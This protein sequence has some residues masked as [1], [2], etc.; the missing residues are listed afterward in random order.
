M[1]KGA[2]LWSLLLCCYFPYAQSQNLIANGGFEAFTDCPNCTAGVQIAGGSISGVGL[3]APWSPLPSFKSPEYYNECAEGMNLPLPC[4]IVSVPINRA[5][6]PNISIWG[7]GENS[8]NAYIGLYGRHND[9][10]QGLGQYEYV[11]QELATPLQAGE[12]Y[13]AGF[14]ARL[15]P[16]AVSNTTHVGMLITDQIPTMLTNPNGDNIGYN[17]DP[18]VLNSQFLSLTEWETYTETFVASGGEKYVIL[19]VFKPFLQQTSS[20][21]SQGDINGAYLLM[22]NVR[23]ELCDDVN[24]SFTTEIE[25]GEQGIVIR[26]EAPN[27]PAT[28]QF[29]LYEM[30][31]AF[32]NNPCTSSACMVDPLNPIAIE[33]GFDETFVVPLEYDKYYII[34]HGVYNDCTPWTENRQLVKLPAASGTISASATVCEGDDILIFPQDIEP[35]GDEAWTVTVEEIELGQPDPLST[36]TYYGCGTPDILNL[37]DPAASGLYDTPLTSCPQSMTPDGTPYSVPCRGDNVLIRVIFEYKVCDRLFQ[38]QIKM[39]ILCAPNVRAIAQP[40]KLCPGDQVY[41]YAEDPTTGQPDPTVTYNW[42]QGGTFLGSGAVVGPFTFNPNDPVASVEAV[43][44]NGCSAKDQVFILLGKNCTEVPDPKGRKKNTGSIGL[45]ENADI[46]VSNPN[47]D[48]LYVQHKLSDLQ[49]ARAEIWNLQGQ[50]LQAVDLAPEK[51]TTQIDISS[52]AEGMY[53]IRIS[54]GETQIHQEKIIVV[55]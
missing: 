43:G 6:G 4:Q 37:T 26:V 36:K 53:V 15:A 45:L 40:S 24:P 16:E 7:F 35:L 19:G 22:D 48:Y 47:Q 39:N 25:C 42:Y 2:M 17:D 10:Q 52:L 51:E 3:A 49:V 27:Q 18:Q 20:V 30:D 11:I 12:S 13:I 21:N 33:F 9:P 54:Q 55:Y 32:Q 44:A 1:K 46:I 34:K 14:S 5:T 38:T 41:Y 23:L 8:Q 28:S 50:L 31:P 29:N